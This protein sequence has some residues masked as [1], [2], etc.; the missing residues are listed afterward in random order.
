MISY[1]I[2]MIQL[3]DA[4]YIL[5]SGTYTNDFHIGQV[6]CDETGLMPS[7]TVTSI[8]NNYKR[9]GYYTVI[10]SDNDNKPVEFINIHN[11]ASVCGRI[12][13]CG[14]ENN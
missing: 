13:E 7:L 5:Y 1:E 4:A 11:P 12:V 2:R 9:L 14:D 6:F 8:I 10:L 3:C